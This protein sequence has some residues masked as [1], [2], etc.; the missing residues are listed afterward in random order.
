[1]IPGEKSLVS[2]SS[3]LLFPREKSFFSLQQFP[4]IVLQIHIFQCL[5]KWL[6]VVSLR[7]LR[8]V[9]VR[10]RTA[11]LIFNLYCQNGSFFFIINFQKFHQFLKCFFI[12]L[13]SCFAVWR[14]GWQRP[15][16]RPDNQPISFRIHFHILRYIV[17]MT[18]FAHAKP[19]NDQF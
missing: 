10:S 6:P 5:G 11:H 7:F 15:T 13:K 12:P 9:P 19:E 16:V 17:R 2:I 4:A 8:V 1:M 18:V 3:K 14:K